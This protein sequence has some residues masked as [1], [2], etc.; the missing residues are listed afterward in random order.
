MDTT[1]KKTQN[2]RITRTCIICRKNKYED[3]FNDE[4]VIPDAISGYY[5]INTV[6]TVCNSR[7]GSKIDVKLTKHTVVE[8][9]RFSLNI[10]GKTGKIPSPLARDYDVSGE[11]GY[12]VRL[13]NSAD[14]KLIPKVLPNIKETGK[15]NEFILILDKTDEAKANIIISKFLNRKG[16]SSDQAKLMQVEYISEDTTLQ[17]Q[18]AIDIKGFKIALLKIAYE[19][20]V[21]QIPK[22]FNDPLSVKISRILEDADYDAAETD[23]EYLNNGI[24]KDSFTL[25]EK[26]VD[27]EN[28]NHYIIL[29][30]I[31]DGGLV[32]L[33][34]IFN[35]FYIAI[36][37]SS[38]LYD[39][40]VLIGKNDIKQRSFKI[41]TLDDIVNQISGPSYL[42]LHYF[43][44]DKED[45]TQFIQRTRNTAITLAEIDGEI[46]LYDS[47]GNF[48]LGIKDKLNQTHLIP[49]VEINE[50]EIIQIF[51]FDEE[52]YVKEIPN[53]LLHRIVGATD[54][55][56]P[57]KRI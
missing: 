56:P 14:G 24:D 39:V 49:E 50:N 8:L 55:R 16:Y 52:L 32:C 11:K 53:G 43:F 40:D 22:Y 44:R 1:S 41:F 19:F 3:D 15:H 18:L 13:E 6:C 20:T 47:K 9:I 5:H 36:K 37:M 27:L 46:S 48:Y 7:I 2:N 10:K 17:G 28:D 30:N 35:F 42:K 54:Y 25:L 26:L 23:I 38:Q 51:K 4:H 21:S 31:P 45:A 29:M 12:R 57:I 33:I 34:K